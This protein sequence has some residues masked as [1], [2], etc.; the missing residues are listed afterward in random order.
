MD[1]Q[2]SGRAG[3]KVALLKDASVDS[4][5]SVFPTGKKS[6]YK[7]GFKVYSDDDDDDSN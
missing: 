5:L 4:K 2:V 1:T 6:I 7:T 3:V